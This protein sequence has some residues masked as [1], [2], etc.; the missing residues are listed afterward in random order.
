MSMTYPP[1]P[2]LPAGQW[3]FLVAGI[4]L[5]LAFVLSAAE[6]AFTSLS[7]RQIRTL[8]KHYPGKMLPWIR[9]EE[10]MLA[11]M[12]IGINLSTTGMGSA[13]ALISR[14]LH[15]P[16][17]GQA[18]ATVGVTVFFGVVTLFFGTILPKVMAR[19]RPEAWAIALS[20][21]VGMLSQ[22]L[23]PVTEPLV[24]ILEKRS[25]SSSSGQMLTTWELKEILAHSSLPYKSK[26]IFTN[27][28]QFASVPVRWT[29]TPRERIFY[30]DIQRGYSEIA[31]AIA[32]SPYSRIPVIRGSLDNVIG[33]VYSR[34]LLLAW[35]SQALVVLEDLLRPV[36]YVQMD[37]PLAESLRVFRTGQQHISLVKDRAGKIRGLLTLEDAVEAIL[38][39]I[40]NESI[41]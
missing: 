3:L 20:K 41:P 13:A 14:G 31:Q 5:A 21:P 39:R 4:L 6:T 11:A 18:A 7:P 9:S 2:N 16:W 17:G 36:H 37:A 10:R 33:I 26:R 35:S 38:E 12:L 30:V 23:A 24:N 28:I 15:S 40:P 29:M 34:D 8:E 25:R 27:L 22:I 19:Q 32:R 1:I